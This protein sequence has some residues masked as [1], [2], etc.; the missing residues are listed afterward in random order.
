MQEF[1]RRFKQHILPKGFTK[2]RSYGYL[3]NRNRQQR[4]NEVLKQ[5]KLPQ[6][7]GMIKVPLPI[8]LLEQYGIN[9]KQC[10]CCQKNTMELQ[11]I[12]QPWKKGDDG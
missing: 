11:V 2:I 1:I 10:P 4:I 5:M 12:Y 9:V 7:K 3:S 6:H 8:H